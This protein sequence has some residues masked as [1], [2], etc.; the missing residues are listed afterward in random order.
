M[1]TLR[2]LSIILLACGAF[3]MALVPLAFVGAAV[4]GLWRLQRHE[5]LPSWLRLAQA[6]V[7]LGRSYVKLAMRAAVRPI[8]A[9]HSVLAT[10]QRWL[11][12][13]MELGG[14]Q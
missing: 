14:N 5:N 1:A 2:D 3:C 7:E 11:G 6:Y 4:Y 10:V 12:A 13:I 9:V 8:C